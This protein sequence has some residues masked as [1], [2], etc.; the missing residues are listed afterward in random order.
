MALSAEAYKL[1]NKKEF[2]RILEENNFN[3]LADKSQ[4]N[5]N[6]LNENP[7]LAI[8]ANN[9]SDFYIIFESKFY[10][11]YSLNKWNERERLIGLVSKTISSQ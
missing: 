10:Q 5:S 3:Y 7:E 4:I 6:N 11:F 9:K 8:I 1:D 2:I